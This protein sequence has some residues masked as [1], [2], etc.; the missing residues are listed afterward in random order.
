[1][2]AYLLKTAPLRL[3]TYNYTSVSKNAFMAGGRCLICWTIQFPIGTSHRSP[4]LIQQHN[5][6]SIRRSMGASGSSSST[7]ASLSSLSATT[8]GGGAGQK[9]W[10]FVG[11]GNPGRIKRHRRGVGLR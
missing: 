11:L 8:G 4:S 5:I 1:M 2:A 3:Q 10:L 7:A 6:F 9:P